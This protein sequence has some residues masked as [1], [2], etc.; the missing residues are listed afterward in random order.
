MVSLVLKKKKN[1]RP[2]KD[3]KVEKKAPLTGIS[4]LRES[5]PAR[6]DHAMMIGIS[7]ATIGV[8]LRIELSAAHGIVIFTKVMN[9]GERVPMIPTMALSSPPVCSMPA[10]TQYRKK[11]VRT[12][13]LEKP[14]ENLCVVFFF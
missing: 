4:S 1:T 2:E 14:A 13:V 10:A 8:L 5:M 9:S 6:C 12:P 11:T 3:N 7:I